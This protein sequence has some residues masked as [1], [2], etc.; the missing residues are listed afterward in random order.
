MDV[1][2]VNPPFER[3][4]ETDNGYFPLGLGYLAAVLRNNKHTVK[5]YNADMGKETKSFKVF[6]V[7]N[8]KRTHAL[9]LNA[10]KNEHHYV[11]KE[12]EQV[13]A[14]QNPEVLGITVTSDMY[15]SALKI[16]HI[17]KKILPK[18]KIIV[19]GVHATLRYQTVIKNKDIDF[20]VRGEGEETLIELVKVLESKK[21]TYARI[22]G[23]SFKIGKKVVHNLDRPFIEDINKLPLPARD[24]VL[25]PELYRASDMNLIIAS[26]GC[27]FRCTFCSSSQFWKHRY[28]TRYVDSIVRELEYVINTYDIKHFRFWDDIFTS[29]KEEL[30]KLCKEIIRRKIHKKVHWNCLT[31]INSLDAERLYWLKKAGCTK[32][33]LG[34]ESGSDKI[35]E[36]MN[37]N[38]TVKQ[39]MNRVKQI[40]KA[41]FIL[42][43]YIIIGMPDELETDIFATMSL[44]K[45]I[46]AQVI[47]VHTLVPYP[48]TAVSAQLESSGQLQKNYD[49]IEPLNPYANYTQLSDKRFNELVNEMMQLA[50]KLSDTNMLQLIGMAWLYRK[51]LIQD[52][53]RIM[54]EVKERL[55]TKY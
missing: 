32:I 38:L 19:G 27:P 54:K 26:R 51:S 45:K 25:F 7:I 11:W 6:S 40:R 9:Y 22:K 29:N 37:K 47:M 50:R 49:W 18:C 2:L 48:G 30:I 23:L 17:A 36:S 4:R 28:R 43:A 39:T 15:P 44:M 42:H 33:C 3:L 34:I 41:G 46:N 52:P 53:R 8:R 55:F 21:K 14:D 13:I 20:V 24:C 5:I 16:A 31:R 10:L 12:I 35:L 1:L